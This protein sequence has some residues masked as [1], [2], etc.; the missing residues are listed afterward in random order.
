MARRK[1]RVKLMPLSKPYKRCY[2]IPFFNG[3]WISPRS[4]LD[5][6]SHPKYAQN[7]EKY[8]RTFLLLQKDIIELFD[9]IEPSDTNLKCY[10]HRIHELLMRACVEFEANC[11]AILSENNYP[12]SIKDLNMDDYKKLDKTHMLS[13]YEVQIP[14]WDGT[15]DKRR[16][17]SSWATG[18]S[19]KWWVAYNGT[20]HNIHAEFQEANLEN[21][22]EAICGLVVILTAQF[23]RED[24]KSGSL[25]LTV[26][27]NQPNGT[28]F[29]IG[30][31]F[32]IK[33]AEWPE[34]GRYEF[35]W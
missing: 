2:R 23:G 34:S 12:K 18:I 4:T 24:F 7:P 9:Y 16:P 8:V 19:P 17:F 30:D 10:S 35:D 15:Q 27:K 28:D 21:L 25:P 13:S 6:V 20:K 33:T 3:N 32:W 11:R 22:M 29:T 26:F 14:N 31:F 5:F 1:G